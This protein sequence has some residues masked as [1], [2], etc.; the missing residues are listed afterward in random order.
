MVRNESCY[1]EAPRI[2][3]QDSSKC[4]KTSRLVR[5]SFK[6]KEKAKGRSNAQ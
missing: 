5:A 3:D 1:Q 4:P 2:A 6:D